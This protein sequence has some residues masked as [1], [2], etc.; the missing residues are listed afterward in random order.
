MYPVLQSSRTYVPQG[1]TMLAFRRSSHPVVLTS[2]LLLTGFLLPGCLMEEPV[3]ELDEQGVPI[4]TATTEVQIKGGDELH[5][6]AAFV[7]IVD[8]EGVPAANVEVFGSFTGDID[9]SISQFTDEDGIVTF[10]AAGV[11]GHL[12]V[13]FQV[14][15]IQYDGADGWAAAEVRGEPALP[16]SCYRLA[17]E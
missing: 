16:R 2:L 6:P 12:T 11:N 13:G 9:D 15:A 5:V 14:E 8:D 4:F 3:A 1:L 7:T 17:H 10:K